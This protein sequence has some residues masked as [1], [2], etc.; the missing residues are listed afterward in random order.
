LTI[1]SGRVNRKNGIGQVRTRSPFTRRNLCDFVFLA[2]FSMARNY[3]KEPRSKRLHLEPLES[4]NLLTGVPFGAA[5]T[6]TGEVMLGDVDVTVV[7]FESDGTNGP[8]TEDWNDAY[9]NEVKAKIEEGLGWW[10][11]MLR[12]ENTVHEL[13]YHINY[14][15]AD[16]PIATGYEPIARQ[17]DYLQFYADDFLDTVGFNS[18]ND[19]IDDVVDFNH[20]QRV[21]SGSDWAFT[22]FVIND[23]NDA[24]GRFE[25]NGTFAS[26]F[27]IS[28]GKFL[29]LPANRP[30]STV[31]HETGHI[32]WGRD[33][34]SG[35]GSYFDQRGYYNA[36]NTNAH[37]NPDPSYV[38]VDSIMGS[39]G[40]ASRAFDNYTTSE[41]SLEQV[42]WRDSDNDG[43]FDVI[44]VPH[45]IE[46]TG[47]YDSRL[48]AYRF[49]GSASVQTLENRNS[50]GNQSDITLNEIT[51]IEY[52]IDGGDWLTALEVNDYSTQLDL[53]ISV[54]NSQLHQVEL[55]AIDVSSTVTSEIFVGDNQSRTSTIDS[56]IGGHIWQDVNAN[57]QWDTGEPNLSARQL[58]IV[59]GNSPAS[60]SQTYDQDALVEGLNV[61]FLSGAAFSAVGDDTDGRAVAINTQ[62]SATGPNV[63]GT[64]SP[65][66]SG[67]TS[68]WTGSSR[69]LRIEFSE[70]TSSVSI[71][72]IGDEDGGVARLDAYDIFG[73]LID[74]NTS[75]FIPT[76]NV[77]TLTINR[78]IADIAH[79]VVRGY[80][81]TDIHLDHLIVGPAN[82]ATT[83]TLGRFEIPGLGI[84]TF[85]VQF[86]NQTQSVTVGVSGIEDGV[87]FGITGVVWHNLENRHDVNGDGSIAPADVLSLVNHINQQQG[88]S[89]LPAEQAPIPVFYDVNNDG[90]VS[91]LDALIV[92]NEINK[93][94]N[95]QP[96]GIEPLNSAS[97]A[98]NDVVDTEP[99]GEAAQLKTV[100]TEPTLL[101][102]HAVA[103]GHSH[104]SDTQ[105]SAT[106]NSATHNSATHNS[107]THNSATFELD[108]ESIDSS[109][110]NNR[111]GN[112]SRLSQHDGE[113]QFSQ[114]ADRVEWNTEYTTSEYRTSSGIK[115][116]DEGLLFRDADSDERED[117][118]TL[119]AKDV[120]GSSRDN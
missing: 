108:A 80:A 54:D 57:G 79:V 119:L 25:P 39:S 8:S 66:E 77:H 42:G 104:N 49:V 47:F 106:H 44:D 74:R 18:S 59:D 114:Q 31:A 58:T 111:I 60:L 107:A 56:G 41:S 17:S 13:N 35:G 6:D 90:L 19:F 94:S 53:S 50:R 102:L 84:G 89:I 20:S 98:G 112:R 33:E 38:H 12:R 48:Q 91:P 27:A 72:A 73:N 52:R 11:E 75:A 113:Q 71:D 10:E 36:L 92:I 55:R 46:G 2:Y 81:D 3:R 70:V 43:I 61:N 100:S 28:G 23:E 30:A 93:G 67:L 9:R 51:R 118:L 109:Q 88:N 68:K 87:E 62:Y 45:K 34:Y 85:D 96:E 105:N 117:L 116:D 32:F 120:S 82:S 83:D 5:D 29:V 15:Y 78:P 63:Y 26:A 115:R 1:A 97:G 99:A 101:R 64:H 4:R 40:V 76:G 86:E 95:G 16:N 103:N 69:Q 7:F 14:Q 24:D 21:A 65:I 110:L 22:M 37:D